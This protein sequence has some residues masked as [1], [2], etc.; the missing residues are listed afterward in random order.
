MRK[1]TIYTEQKGRIYPFEFNKTVANVFDDMITRSVPMY[2]E[3]LLR[4]AQLAALFYKKNS[5]VYD[6]GCSNGN[7]G[8]KFKQDMIIDYIN[9]DSGFSKTH[10]G[11]L[12]GTIE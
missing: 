3:I 7:F 4:Q 5:L 11:T 12:S 10:K 2:D 1:D 6:L 9:Q 8:E